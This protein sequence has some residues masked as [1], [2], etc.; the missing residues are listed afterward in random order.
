VKTINEKTQEVDPEMNRA[1]TYLTHKPY[2]FDDHQEDTKKNQT[3][4]EELKNSFTTIR[5]LPRKS[6]HQKIRK[7]N[8]KKVSYRFFILL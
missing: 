8:Q 4:E 5:K 1:Q 2:N 3:P 7:R 6:D